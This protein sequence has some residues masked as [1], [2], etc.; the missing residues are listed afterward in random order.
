[1]R[2]EIRRALADGYKP[3]EIMVVCGAAHASALSLEGSDFSFDSERV[4]QAKNA[5]AATLTLIPYSY[6]RL[7]EQ[8]GY[9]AGNRAPA[10]YQ[11]VW[12]NKG[13]FGA[14]TRRFLLLAMNTLHAQ[15]HII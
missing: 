3:E 14:A 13:D 7:S 4:Q 11:Q 15:G 10:Y 1:M 12:E 5:K 6:A 2:A 9:G 8:S